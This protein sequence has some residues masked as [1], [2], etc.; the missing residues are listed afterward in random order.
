MVFL[1][2]GCLGGYLRVIS[3]GCAYCTLCVVLNFWKVFKIRSVW[4]HWSR[5]GVDGFDGGFFLGPRGQDVWIW[6]HWS[7]KRI[8][9][10]VNGGI[11]ECSAMEIEA[12]RS[13]CMHRYRRGIDSLNSFWDDDNERCADQDTHPYC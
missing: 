2:Y 12:P 11:V 1:D 5:E 9:S 8:Y 3:G 13:M 10:F 4:H 7:W 6:Y